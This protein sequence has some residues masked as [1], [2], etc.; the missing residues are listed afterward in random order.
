MSSVPNNQSKAH[1]FGIF[2]HQLCEMTCSGDGG[3]CCCC[4]S[5]CICCEGTVAVRDVVVAV[6]VVEVEVVEVV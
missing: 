1:F 4:S 2:P 3:Y 6:F 5:C